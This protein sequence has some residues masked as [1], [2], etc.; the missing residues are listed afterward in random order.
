[1][2]KKIAEIVNEN[3]GFDMIESGLEYLDGFNESIKELET[4]DYKSICVKISNSDSVYKIVQ[5]IIGIDITRKIIDLIIEDLK[6]RR[7]RSE[8]RIHGITNEICNIAFA[9]RV[10]E[11]EE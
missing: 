5:P 3:G 11:S 10:K 2:L 1:M 7:D 4:A 9:M 6:E 8:K